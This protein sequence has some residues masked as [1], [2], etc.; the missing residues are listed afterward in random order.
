MNVQLSKTQPITHIK[1][2]LHDPNPQ[3]PHIDHHYPTPLHLMFIIHSNMFVF[4][5]DILLVLLVF[6]LHKK[7]LTLL[8]CFGTLFNFLLRFVC[9]IPC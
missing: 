9:I 6:E 3:L 1:P 2:V 4:I 5:K 8:S 7:C